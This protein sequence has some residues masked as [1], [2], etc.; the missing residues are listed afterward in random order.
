MTGALTISLATGNSLVVDNNVLVVDATNNRV[1]FG[2]LTPLEQVDVR[3]HLLALQFGAAGSVRVGRGQ[4]T[5]ASPAPVTNGLSLGSYQ[6]RGYYD[7]INHTIGADIL[8]VAAADWTSSTN[9]RTYIALRT[10]NGTSLA[11]RARLTDGGAFLIGK[12][13]GLTGAGDL[14]ANGRVRGATF[15]TANGAKWALQGWTTN[16]DAAI[17]GYVTVVIDGTTRKLATIA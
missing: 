12:T 8:A 6:F 15:E 7:G 3:G 5:E 9:V 14:D 4:G 2:T 17:Q 13:S 11:E 1:G 16:A 10:N